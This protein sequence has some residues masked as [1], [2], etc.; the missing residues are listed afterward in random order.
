VYFK[1]LLLLFLAG[2]IIL[3][4][5]G[6]PENRQNSPE[7]LTLL[8]GSALGM[9]LMV[10]SLNL[11]MIV[12]AIELASLPSYAI[13]AFNKRRRTAA[14]ASL[15]Y[16]VFGGVSTAIMVYGASLLYG[17]FHTLNVSEIA[18]RA[19][20]SIH[21]GHNVITLAVALASFLAGVA[22]KIAA[23]PFHFWC[24]DA[25]EGA[26]I[27]VTTWLSVASKAAGIVL[28]MRLV[29][30]FAAAAGAQLLPVETI[31]ALAW[32]IGIVAAVTC[33][34]GN[35]AAYRQRSLKRLLAYSSIAHA[36]YMLMAA[37]VLVYPGSE[38]A[39]PPIAAV[40]V[41]LLIYVFMNLGAFGVV[42]MVIWQTG[43]DAL[44]AFSGLGRRAPWLAVPMLFC[45]VSLVGL[46][47]FGGFV[48]KYWLLL[49]LGEQGGP[50]AGL[51]WCL[52]IVAV[53]NTLISL[54]YYFRIVREMFLSDD[55]Q[56]A[57]TPSFSGTAIVNLCA[58]V[59]LLTGVIFI[60]Q[61]KNT[62]TRYARNLYRADFLRVSL[63]TPAST[64]EDLQSRWTSGV[65]AVVVTMEKG[66]PLPNPDVHRESSDEASGVETIP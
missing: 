43:S 12:I 1:F 34:V 27:E 24:P 64:N 32:G 38:P 40:L 17:L 46:P 59:L 60:G 36:G 30:T 33:T 29:D 20:A 47:P 10:S 41:Y 51:Y 39:T 7:F 62:A 13:V 66:G 61:P 45:L 48:A 63:H 57:W 26:D 37:A 9:V 19:L 3:R 22:F 2:V 42:A 23:V 65:D 50:L 49:A 21:D 15:K 31:A 16:V 4:F 28:L 44:S 14:E 35:F 58:I 18:F 8:I 25:F 52:I 5:I 55:G 11:L 54:F 53:I 6:P 56:P